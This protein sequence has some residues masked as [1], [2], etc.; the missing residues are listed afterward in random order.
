MVVAFQDGVTLRSLHEADD[1]GVFSSNMRN[2]F[3][4][5]MSIRC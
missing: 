3:I 2:R 4:G 1:D 5:H